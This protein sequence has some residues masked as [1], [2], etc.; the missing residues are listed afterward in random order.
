MAEI[1]AKIHLFGLCALLI[2]TAMSDSRTLIDDDEEGGYG[3]ADD[4]V[5]AYRP[6]ALLS[7]SNWPSRWQPSIGIGSSIRNLPAATDFF[8]VNA[9]Q[10]R[11]SA[12]F[13]A[14]MNANN[15]EQQIQIAALPKP[16]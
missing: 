4:V 13:D 15:W 14:F 1:N 2:V 6:T 7:H 11:R 10:R 9:R 8:G 5:V 16:R 3:G 12:G